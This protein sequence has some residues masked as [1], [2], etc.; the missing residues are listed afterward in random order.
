GFYK[1][2]NKFIFNYIDQNFTRDKFTQQFPDLANDLGAD[3]TYVF[4]QA[5]NGQSVDVYGFEVALQRQLD[6]LP[7]FLS[8]FGIYANY[9]YTHSKAKGIAGD[10]VQR[11][12]LMLP[13]TA[14]YMFNSSLSWENKRFSARVSL[15][16][17][18]SYLD[19][20]GGVAFDDRYYDKQTFLDANVS[21]AITEKIRFF[22]EA[23]N[24]T[25]QPLRYYQGEKNR[26]MQMEYYKP[27]YNVGLKFDF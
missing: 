23:N 2:I 10:D 3:N 26:T 13:G 1:K 25:N 11:E 21:Y 9:T 22:V 16:Y 27:R 20:I 17:T 19:E 24:L 4:S 7:G 5:R 12:G 15:N 18:A 14:P 8:H 6:F